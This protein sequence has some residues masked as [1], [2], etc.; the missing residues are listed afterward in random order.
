L[1][2]KTDEIMKFSIMDKRKQKSEFWTK[3]G[4]KIRNLD[5]ILDVIGDIEQTRI[6]QHIS[7][8]PDDTTTAFDFC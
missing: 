8:A 4:S 7:C 3:F 1:D 5:R 6:G 2:K